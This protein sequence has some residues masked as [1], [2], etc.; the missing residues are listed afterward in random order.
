MN[1]VLYNG[2]LWVAGG[3]NIKYSN[4][5][6][7]WITVANSP[8]SVN[9][10]AWTGSQWL[11]SCDGSNNLYTSNNAI[12]WYLNNSLSAHNIY[13]IAYDPGT[14]TVF[15]L[16][17]STIY[18][19]KYSNLGSWSSH[20]DASLG[21][22]TD[23]TYTGTHHS[24]VG[25]SYVLL[26][27]DLVSWTKI[28]KPSTGQNL[29]INSSNQ[30]TATVKPMVVA[31]ADSSNNSLLYSND[32][33]MWY[34]LGT[35][36]FTRANAV[37]WNGSLWLA[38]G[39][40]SNKWY[41]L[42]RDGINWLSQ[43]D[44]TL[45]EGTSVAWNGSMWMAAGT[46]SG[47]ATVVYSSNGVSWTPANING[48]TGTSAYVAWNGY[49][50][51]VNAGSKVFSSVSAVQ[52]TQEP[53]A[54]GDISGITVSAYSVSSNGPFTAFPWQSSAATYDASSGLFTGVSGEYIQMD[55]G[56]S[57]QINHYVLQS[58]ASTW[59]MYGSADAS[60]WT[61]VDTRSI[62]VSANNILLTYTGT[63]AYR[64]YKLVVEKVA[65]GATYAQIN[66][67]ALYASGP[68]GASRPLTVHKS[69]TASFVGGYIQY[70]GIPGAY[71]NGRSLQTTG[72]T[73]SSYA[74]D[75]QHS[76]VTNNGTNVYYGATDFSFNSTNISMNAS[77][78]CYNGTFFFAGGPN[79][80]YAHPS[81]L[82][83]W[84]STVNAATLLGASGTVK[85][86]KSNNE[87]G[88]VNA[89]NA[90]YVMPGEKLSIVAPRFYDQNMERRGATFMVSL[91]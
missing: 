56:A 29:Y 59:T 66:N 75:G 2:T 61:A 63:A 88:F 55:V 74:Y 86:L 72:P 68:G 44:N 17:D 42:S 54:T 8:T 57:T 28:T 35:S 58:N 32:G 24:F 41:A 7:T 64:Y 45:D 13:K 53:I 48:L 83:T 87:M 91:E 38:V 14:A 73:S 43:Y 25:G 12:H 82:T 80:K 23:Y 71:L 47:S 85:M 37:D 70:L 5:G 22:I 9:S 6:I 36:V 30:G 81:D 40:G 15:A 11:A 90:L 89:P 39:T 77:S 69:W 19:A 51:L 4:N 34:G 78:A 26:S 79:I 3:T 65:G 60:T 76:L 1:A 46:K 33:L 27:Q 84:Y 62:D 31:C 21:A 49:K 18:Y 16:S 20:T 50:W 52:W 67:V 10:L